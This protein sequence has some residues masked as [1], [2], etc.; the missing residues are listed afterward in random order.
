MNTNTSELTAADVSPLEPAA[1]PRDDERFSRLASIPFL[2][3]H[4]MCLFAFHTG[5]TVRDLI[6][7]AAIYSVRIWAITV[8]YHRYFSHRSFKTSRVFQFVMA[9]AGSITCHKGVL[10][11]AGVHRLHHRHTDREGDPH[12]PVRRGFWW[13]HARWVLCRRYDETRFDVVKDLA[14]YPELRWI[15]DWHLIPNIAFAAFLLWYGGFSVLVWGYFV[16]ATLAY[17]V[18][19]CINSVT[20]LYGSRRYATKDSSRNVPLL[21][22]LGFG[23]GWHN[24]HHYRPNTANLGWFWWEVDIG[25]YSLKVLSWLGIVWDLRLPSHKAKYAHL[26]GDRAR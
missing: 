1:P 20:H 21:G 10:W 15:N 12:S 19:F 26:E 16:S 5:V 23:E 7:C 6:W 13:G 17:H 9:L 8:A 24:N 22:L 25:Y 18:V 4:V 2:T 11:W 3:V 14:K